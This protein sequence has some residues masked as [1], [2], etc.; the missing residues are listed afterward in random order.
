MKPKRSGD[1][2][3]DIHASTTQVAS[4]RAARCLASI[5]DDDDC[6]GS[7]FP[8]MTDISTSCSTDS[9]RS[10]VAVGSP[11]REEAAA[12]TVSDVSSPD[13][14]IEH[15]DA[16]AVSPVAF[17]RACQSP[18]CIS[19][20]SACTL[21]ALSHSATAATS[22]ARFIRCTA[23]A[24]AR[25]SGVRS[26]DAVSRATASARRRL[27][28]GRRGNT[29]SSGAEDSPPSSPSSTTS[30]PRPVF[31]EGNSSDDNQE[32][33]SATKLSIRARRS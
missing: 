28:T 6:T 30:V 25:S 17:A 9:R 16:L 15:V 33:P 18:C 4:G 23:H 20:S 11:P 27:S 10:G 8:A 2:E 12:G 1:S 31:H 29:R 19:L 14:P 7:R 24:R 21:E 13:V 5:A 26:G 32:E 22:S 3:S